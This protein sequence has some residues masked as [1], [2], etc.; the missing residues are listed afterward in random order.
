[1]DNLRTGTILLLLAFCY[2]IFWVFLS[3]YLFGQSVMATVA[4]QIDLP[5][6][7]MCPSL[8][9]SKNTP[10]FK[11]SLLGLGDILLPGILV[12]F[13]LKFEVLLGRGAKIFIASLLGYSIGLTLCIESLLIYN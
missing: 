3:P 4:T 13:V 5:M 9:P 2:D 11:C 8:I 6:K 12:K 10:L 1:M 7:F